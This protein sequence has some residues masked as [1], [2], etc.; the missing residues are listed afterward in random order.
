[1]AV[2]VT[3]VLSQPTMTVGTTQSAKARFDGIEEGDNTLDQ[4][5][6]QW[7]S[8]NPSIA[9][10]TSSATAVTIKAVA[11]GTAN[12]SAAIP[13]ATVVPA[14]VAVGLPEVAITAQQEAQIKAFPIGTQFRLAGPTTFFTVQVSG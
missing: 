2:T 4:R 7:T 10:V 11:P 3:V 9:S 13:G 8:S 12:I 5:A 1:M 14:S 6:I